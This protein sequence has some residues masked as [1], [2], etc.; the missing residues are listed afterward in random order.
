MSVIGPD[1]RNYHSR[2]V[3]GILSTSSHAWVASQ[4]TRSRVSCAGPRLKVSLSNVLRYHPPL[5]AFGVVQPS[6]L[7]SFLQH[8]VAEQKRYDATLSGGHA[9]VEST[10]I[11]PVAEKPTP[12]ADTLVVLPN[13]TKKAR[14]GT[15]GLYGN[16]GT[17]CIAPLGRFVC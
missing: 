5:N 13:D 14:K 2:I 17:L 4:C 10:Q 7:V 1:I 8:H 15:K 11:Q 16:K 12:A 3:T 9:A 6:D